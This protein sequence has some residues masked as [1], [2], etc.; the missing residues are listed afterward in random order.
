MTR[1]FWNELNLPPE[2]KYSLNLQNPAGGGQGCSWCVM[3]TASSAI[4]ACSL[5]W[6]TTAVSVKIHERVQGQ[7]LNSWEFL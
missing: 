7:I 2:R 3:S 5:T 4:R 1:G 6:T